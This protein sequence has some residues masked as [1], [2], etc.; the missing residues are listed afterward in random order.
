LIPWAFE[1]GDESTIHPADLVPDSPSDWILFD[2]QMRTHPVDARLNFN[3]DTTDYTE[4]LNESFPEGPV[5]SQGGRVSDDKCSAVPWLDESQQSIEGTNESTYWVT[6][7]DDEETAE[8][9]RNEFEMRSR[10]LLYET[11]VLLKVGG[12]MAV[13]EGA[14]EVAAHRYDKAIQYCAVALMKYYEG[15]IYLKQL[16]SGHFGTAT[17]DAEGKP[18]NKS[19]TII[20]VWSP[21]LRILITSRLNMALLLLKPEFS[22]ASRASDQARAA[23]KLL[24]PFTREEGKVVC[25]LRDKKEHVLSD[26]EPMETYREAKALQARAY[27]RLGSS[28]LEMGDYSASIKSFELSMRSSSVTSPNTKPDSL[29]VRRLQDAKRKHKN[30]K[31]RDRKKFQRLL[32]EQDESTGA[33]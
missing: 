27:F 4:L 12:N 28:E 18:C 11:A 17:E 13:K 24:L 6:R 9:K 5:F 32:D 33:D 19:A 31:K 7:E 1:P 21:L 26:K 2:K 30:K 20:A 8:Q 29:L 3:T 14:L 23:L 15:D 22:L 16:T 10:K 25:C